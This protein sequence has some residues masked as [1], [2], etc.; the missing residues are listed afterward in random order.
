MSE[1]T[2]DRRTA[3]LSEFVVTY[4][5]GGLAQ[6][7]TSADEPCP[8]ETDGHRCAYPAGHPPLTVDGCQ[9]A[10]HVPGLVSWN[11]IP[12]VPAE[13]CPAT[14]PDGTVRCAGAV[15][16]PPFPGEDD[17]LFDH[18]VPSLGVWWNADRD[19]ERCTSRAPS[20]ITARCVRPAGHAG[21]HA[22]RAQLADGTVRWQDAPTPAARTLRY[23]ECAG[24]ALDGADGP[25][26]CVKVR[27]HDGRCEDVRGVPILTPGERPSPAMHPVRVRFID[28]P[29]RVEQR[30][31]LGVL[32]NVS[33]HGGFALVVD[34]FSTSQACRDAAPMWEQFGAKIGAHTVLC[35]P[36]ELDIV[37]WFAD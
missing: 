15:G 12:A 16:H 7:A 5:N 8:A 32:A 19:D 1:E 28:L 6:V 36:G 33:V 21:L 17:E 25:R 11:P 4:P 26:Y 14:N 23:D 22:P 9:Y 29:N 24:L 13:R 34:R 10:H 37:S 35:Y 30:N 2:P 31:M 3:H 18:A 27:G 20:D